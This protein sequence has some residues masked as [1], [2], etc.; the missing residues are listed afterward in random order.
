MFEA[1][2]W[3]GEKDHARV[4]ELLAFIDYVTEWQKHRSGTKNIVLQYGLV[5][6]ML[7][8]RYMSKPRI[9]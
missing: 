8:Y 9:L 5:N 4:Q 2:F 3:N 6:L 1:L 7:L